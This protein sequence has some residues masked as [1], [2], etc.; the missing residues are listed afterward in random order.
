VRSRD[1]EQLESILGLAL[2][3]ALV[4]GCL[5]SVTGGV[6]GTLFG[7]GWVSTGLAEVPAIIGRLPDTLSDPRRAWPVV[8]RPALPGPAGFAAAFLLV[9]SV[10]VGIAAA[11][12]RWRARRERRH[13][14]AAR[15][16]R[17]GD[18]APLRDGKPGDGHVALGRVRRQVIAAE[19]HQS[20][21]VVAPTQTGK[22]TGLAVPAIL[23][24]D[25]PVLATSIK[26]DLVRDT[27]RRRCAVGDVRIFD[28]TATTGLPR[29]DWTPL[30][31]CADWQSARRTADRLTHAA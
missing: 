31:Q 25:G 30:A 9:L 12:L 15:W 2:G 20:V 7:D 8:H 11:A 23:E 1:D 13:P 27:L 5:V 28:P 22:T 24:W 6:A 16:A 14:R 3:G 21:L 4:V 26:S 19:R 10:P 18:L 17:R 29:A